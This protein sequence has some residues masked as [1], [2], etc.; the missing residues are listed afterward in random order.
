MGLLILEG[1]WCFHWNSPSRKK[2]QKNWGKMCTFQKLVLFILRNRRNIYDLSENDKSIKMRY[3]N[4]E[5]CK[6]NRK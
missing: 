4:E 3:N 1:V 6:T 2:F 5:D